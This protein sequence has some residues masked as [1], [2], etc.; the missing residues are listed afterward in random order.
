FV[1][2]YAA[3]TQS[4]KLDQMMLKSGQQYQTQANHAMTYASIVYPTLLFACVAAVI[5]FTIF[6]VYGGY[7]DLLS[8][9]AE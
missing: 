8:D 3:G 2:F 1:S 4:G 7:L 9:L 5:V 6:Q